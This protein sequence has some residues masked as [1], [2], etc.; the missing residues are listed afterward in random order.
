[1]QR[2]CSLVKAAWI[3]Q[4]SSALL[5]HQKTKLSK[6]KIITDS[7]TNFTVLSLKNTDILASL[8]SFRLFI[9]NFPRNVNI[10]EMNFIHLCMKLSLRINHKSSIIKSYFSIAI[11]LFPRDGSYSIHFLFPANFLD[12]FK[13]LR[14]LEILCE[15][16]HVI[17]CVG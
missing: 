11:S 3:N 9:R 14:I 16:D 12:H 8:E 2:S 7:Q 5:S 1:M 6:S 13:C 17:F 4:Y 15:L 10:K